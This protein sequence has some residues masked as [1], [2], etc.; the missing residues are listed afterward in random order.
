MTGDTYDR[1]DERRLRI[2][3]RLSEPSEVLRELPRGDVEGC[4]ARCPGEESDGPGPDA[5]RVAEALEAVGEAAV[6]ARSLL[7][8]LLMRRV[9]RRAGL[10]S[11]VTAAVLGGARCTLAIIQRRFDL[12]CVDSILVGAFNAFGQQYCFAA[13]SAPLRVSTTS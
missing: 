6:Q 7:A 11:G 3:H 8:A 9:G 13:F 4:R 10:I 5:Q 2:C 1:C 12:F